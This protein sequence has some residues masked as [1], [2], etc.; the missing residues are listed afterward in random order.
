[1]SNNPLVFIDPFGETTI[2]EYKVLIAGRAYSIALHGGG[3]PWV[4]LGKTIFCVHLQILTYLDGVK[5][6]HWRKQIPLIW[7]KTSKFP[8]F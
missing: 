7:C 8:R 5:G 1:M 3:H 2:V 4:I 6:S